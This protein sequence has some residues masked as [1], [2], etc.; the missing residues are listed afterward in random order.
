MALAT[1]GQR[2]RPMRVGARSADLSPRRLTRFEGD[3]SDLSRVAARG[4]LAGI[5]GQ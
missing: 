5:G 1:V 2:P 3:P 4:P